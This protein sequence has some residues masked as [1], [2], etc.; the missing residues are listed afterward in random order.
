MELTFYY[1]IAVGG[2]LTKVIDGY[3]ADFEKANPGVKVKPIYAGNY[4]DAR[5]KALAALKAGQPAQIS[6]LFSIDVY[7]LLEQDVIMAW[8]DVATT[9]DDKAWLKSFYP[10]LM[11][12]GTYKNK[13]YGIP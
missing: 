9:A 3:A 13:V 12:N 5:I 2:P 6:V 11:M 1:P 8:D 10:A 7:E 4:D